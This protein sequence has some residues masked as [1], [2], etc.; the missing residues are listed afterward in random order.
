MIY[1][2][3]T[4]HVEQ[5][6]TPILK[7]HPNLPIIV[8]QSIEANLSSAESTNSL[9]QRGSITHWQNLARALGKYSNFKGIDV[10]SWQDFFTGK[11]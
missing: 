3:N 5:I 11:P 8:V 9:G 7:S 4:D 1:I 10:Q 6:I 2:R